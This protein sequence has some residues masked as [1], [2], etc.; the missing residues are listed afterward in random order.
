MINKDI[1]WG[2]GPRKHDGTYGKGQCQNCGVW[3]SINGINRGE[4]FCGDWCEATKRR[5]AN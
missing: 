2:P 5:G 1:T 3:L 4:R